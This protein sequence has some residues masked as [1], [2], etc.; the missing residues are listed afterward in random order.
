MS[1][2][3]CVWCPSEKE[4]KEKKGVF[5]LVFFRC[6]IKKIFFY[7]SFFYLR[8]FFLSDR[9]LRHKKRHCQST[10]ATCEN[11]YD[12]TQNDIANVWESVFGE[13]NFQ[14]ISLNSIAWRYSQGGPSQY[15]KWFHVTL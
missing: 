13:E 1:E 12:I 7:F 11:R 8:F 14:N 3:V 4:R 10:V 15:Q 5:V 6:E 9:K 2:C